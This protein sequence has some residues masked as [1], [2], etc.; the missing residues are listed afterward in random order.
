MKR[1]TRIDT[2][3]VERGLVE[4]RAKAQRMIMAGQVRLD[5][6]VVAKA[7][8][9]A[10]PGASL[11]VDRGPRYVSRGGDKLDAALKAFDVRPEGWVCAD[12]GASTGGFTDC[13]LQHGASRIYAIDVGRGQLHWR[14]R[15]DPRVMPMERTNARE[16]SGLPEMIA[17]AVVDVSFIS[18]R[19]I[20][21]NVMR[22]FADDG[23]VLALVKP[24]FEAGKGV[25]GR[26]GVVREP[27]VHRQVL[28]ELIRFVSSIG[29]VPRG[30][31]RSPLLGPKGNAE[32]ILWLATKGDPLPETALLDDLFPASP[33]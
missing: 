14:L 25:V 10:D 2:L 29:L 9:R 3:L 31:I 17:L 6:E 7:S 4:S 1:K 13:L 21:P 19:L 27:Q 5:G 32:F 22:W 11:T 33:P 26:D 28:E 30:L 23:E 18:L 12:V 15:Q 8:Q 20:L 16:L 24:Q